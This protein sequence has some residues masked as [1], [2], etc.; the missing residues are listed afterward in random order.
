MS[1][2]AL[3]GKTG[4]GKVSLASM[5]SIPASIFLESSTPDSHSSWKQSPHCNIR[6]KCRSTSLRLGLAKDV[7]KE[8]GSESRE[9]AA[10]GGPKDHSLCP[11]NAVHYVGASHSRKC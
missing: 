10:V 2:P 7:R 6:K 11:V 8:L 3:P 9:N 4:P 1:G 5:R